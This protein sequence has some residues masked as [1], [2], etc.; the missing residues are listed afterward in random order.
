MIPAI[1]A[2]A[3]A[4]L[5]YMTL[6]FAVAMKRGRL[7]IV[8]VAWGGAFIVAALTSLFIGFGGA[9]QYLVT[10]LVFIWAFRLSFYIFKRLRV[11]TDED[12][13]YAAMR[14]TWKGSLV[15]NAYF[16]IF[17]V[18]GV[19]AVVVSGSVIA[20]NAAHEGAIGVLAVVGAGVWLMG[21]LFEAV[22][23]AQLRRHLA[24]PKT[25]GMLMTSGLWRYTRHPNYFGEA[26]QWW[27]IYIIALS[28]PGGW[29]TII[30]PLTITFLLLF[31]SGVPL[32][33]RRFK[34]RVGWAEYKQRTS[35][36][37]PLPP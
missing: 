22:G 3:A 32:T 23:D 4:V 18:Q 31:V 17:V 7:D 1:I 33:E 12:P 29:L 9:L 28:V 21:F 11:S 20:V 24:H 27:G 34:G 14:K 6:V 13:R 37:V 36:F 2:V 30:A 15:L 5:L 8:D 16:R 19:L 10:A 35:V 26:V 25:K